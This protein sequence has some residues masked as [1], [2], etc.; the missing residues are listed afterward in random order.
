VVGAAL[1][2][3]EV[4]QLH[5]ARVRDENV[6]RG[7]VPVDQP[8][9][10]AVG[11]PQ[12]VREVGPLAELD[13]DVQG[14]GVRQTQGAPARGRGPRQ[15]VEQR[16]Q[17]AAIDILEDDEVLALL[18]DPEVVDLDDVPVGQRGVDARLGHQHADEPGVTGVG[19]EDPL[20]GD[21]LLEPLVPHR[22]PSIDLGHSANGDAS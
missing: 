10:L 19:R 15:H 12:L 9:R 21:G 20:D 1:G 6:G 5:L 2:E 13:D 18:R 17:V 14:H 16:P 8:Q 4:G 3:P 22:A 11:P 7:D